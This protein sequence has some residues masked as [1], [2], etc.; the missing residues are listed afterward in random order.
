MNIK[1]YKLFTCD[2][3]ASIMATTVAS[4]NL[5]RNGLF[6]AVKEMKTKFSKDKYRYINFGKQ[7]DTALVDIKRYVLNLKAVR[8]SNVNEIQSN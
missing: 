7:N 1:K 6:S 4:N 5:I 8:T 2:E 3:T